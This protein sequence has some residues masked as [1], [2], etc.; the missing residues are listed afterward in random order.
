MMTSEPTRPPE[1]FSERLRPK[2]AVVLQ[3]IGRRLI[4]WRITAN[5]LTLAGVSLM[6]LAG[7]LLA[8]GQFLVGG[9]LIVLSAPLDALDGTVARLSG[10]ESKF[11]AFLDSTSDR[12]AEGLIL[13]GL[14]I[15]GLI[16]QDDWI[17]LLAFVSLWGSLLV[18]YTR[19]RAEGLG[20]ECKI[21]LF[22]RL[23]RFLLIIGML[24]FNL[25][26]PGLALLAALTHLT[27]IQRMVYVY[28]VTR[29]NGT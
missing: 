14:S 13:L 9:L 16:A 17:V 15:Y 2:V 29:E 23:E 22:T 25:V 26:V 3:P 1:S 20:L 5:M 24:V 11:G 8:S 7:A 27:A 10:V 12:Y 18:S 28:H 19:A 4:R 6:A 21:G